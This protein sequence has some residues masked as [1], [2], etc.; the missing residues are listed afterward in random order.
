MSR[1]VTIGDLQANQWN[2]PEFE[3]VWRGLDPDQVSR[4]IREIQADVVQAVSGYESALAAADEERQR[5]EAEVDRLQG[6]SNEEAPAA[7]QTAGLAVTEAPDV[8]EPA[9]PARHRRR[10]GAEAAAAAA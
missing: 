5:L 6:V 8:A 4:F 2:V 7:V 1:E 3:T 10:Q 9:P